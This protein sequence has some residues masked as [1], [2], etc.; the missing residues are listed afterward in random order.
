MGLRKTVV[1]ATIR[2]HLQEAGFPEGLELKQGKHL[3]DGVEFVASGK[4]AGK[5]TKVARLCFSPNG[6]KVVVLDDY[7]EKLGLPVVGVN[8]DADTAHRAATLPAV[9]DMVRE[10]FGDDFV[11]VM[12]NVT[13][14]H[15]LPV[16]VR[17]AVRDRQGMRH[18]V[19]CVAASS[20]EERDRMLDRL[21]GVQLYHTCV[22]TWVRNEPV[23]DIAG[24]IVSQVRLW[25]Q[26]NWP[27]AK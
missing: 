27:K 23:H 21:T 7:R 2:N 3:P 20:H 25:Q 12:D 1:F 9:L 13:P 16:L 8:V 17:I 22:F 15:P 5:C 18:L 14:N 24:K 26:R 11:R 19:D 4:V 6:K 10:K